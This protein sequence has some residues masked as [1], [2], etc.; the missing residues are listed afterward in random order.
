MS[1]QCRGEGQVDLGHRRIL[2]V[3][4]AAR[5]PV[6]VEPSGAEV[7]DEGDEVMELHG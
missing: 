7:P 1:S 3:A 5:V 4:P 6:L 2:A